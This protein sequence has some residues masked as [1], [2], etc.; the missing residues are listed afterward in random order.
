[1][2][3][4][5]AEMPGRGNSSSVKQERGTPVQVATEKKEISSRSRRN[6]AFPGGGRQK[7][8]PSDNRNAERKSF[9]HPE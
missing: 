8:K 4:G 2:N 6:P 9:R 7:G 5:N 1:M 3:E